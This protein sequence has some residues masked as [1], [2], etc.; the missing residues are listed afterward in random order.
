MLQNQ[1]ASNLCLPATNKHLHKHC[2]PQTAT[3]S[4]S[5][6]ARAASASYTAVDSDN[7]YKAFTP[8]LIDVANLLSGA[9]PT[10]HQIQQVGLPLASALR[11]CLATAGATL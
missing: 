8:P 10:Q 4:L 7:S 11:T 1:V 9:P 5:H 3:T 2:R 6:T